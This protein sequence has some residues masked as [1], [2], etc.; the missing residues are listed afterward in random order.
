MLV[1]IIFIIDNNKV[2]IFIFVATGQQ[3]SGGA[4]CVLHSEKHRC[5]DHLFCKHNEL[6]NVH[7]LYL[8]YYYCVIDCMIVSTNNV[9]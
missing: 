2:K 3:T 9:M 8:Y 7:A 1:I 5:P 4:L 6:N